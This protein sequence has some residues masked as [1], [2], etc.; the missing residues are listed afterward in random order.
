MILVDTSVWIDHLRRGN[1]ELEELLE[2]TQVSCH[3]FIIGEL[4]CGS[5]RKRKQILAHLS[6]L[7]S[8]G[9]A[10]H[11]E[12]M[13]LVEG[14]RLMGT[15]IGWVDVHLLAASLIAQNALWTMDRSL[16]AVARQLDVS[17]EQ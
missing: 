1:P 11:V 13:E 12:V 6:R 4:G 5:L 7:P 15:G 8:V 10:T 2:A 16:A 9:L 14:R 3:P 17:A